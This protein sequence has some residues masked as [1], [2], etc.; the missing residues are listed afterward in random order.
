VADVAR[1]NVFDPTSGA[2]QNYIDPTLTNWP[3]AY[4][5]L[6]LPRLVSIKSKYDPETY[7]HSRSRSPLTLEGLITYESLGRWTDI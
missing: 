4:Y 7:S 3:N 1:A 6:N 2:Y 5:G